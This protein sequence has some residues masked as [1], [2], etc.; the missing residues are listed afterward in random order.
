MEMMRCC[1]I[2]SSPKLRRRPFGYS[3]HDRWL[4]GIE[5]REC[6]II[7]L[8]PQPAAA[9]IVQMYSTEYFE[10]DFRCGH[11]GS[12]FEEATLR[13][14]VDHSLLRRIQEFKPSGRFLE[15][16]CAG[17]AFLNAAR[18]A[19]Y[20]VQGVELSDVA[21]QFAREKFGLEVF[22]GE[23]ASA[24]FAEASFDIIYMGDVLEHLPAPVAALQELN[25][26]LAV[27]G[28][29]VLRCPMQTNN[30]FSRLGFLVFDA[31]GKKAAVQLPPYHLF[32][33]RPKSLAALLRHTG[34]DILRTTESAI[35]PQNISLRGPWLHK[36]GKAIL[37]PANYLLTTLFGVFGDRLEVFAT[38]R[39]ALAA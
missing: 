13:H 18:Q 30:L 7:F 38:K 35:P 14:L 22:T 37:Q 1:P 4:E 17:G 29:L 31:L 36:I 11:A 6:G 20:E 12:Y 8:D 10:N 28:L 23:L 9:E 25:R 33:Y 39:R 34:F 26:I 5:C 21:A 3:F 2:C 19:G 15:T 24:N 32:E 27:A 16:G